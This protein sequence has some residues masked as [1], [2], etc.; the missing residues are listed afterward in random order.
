[1]RGLKFN[2][3]RPLRQT[4]IHNGKYLYEKP[5]MYFEKHSTVY[6]KFGMVTVLQMDWRTNFE[7]FKITV[8]ETIV[9]GFIHSAEL[10]EQ[11]LNDR[12]L[13]WMATHFIKNI[14]QRQGS[15]LVT[16]TGGGDLGKSL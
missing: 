9:N 3:P 16:L 4:T 6:T 2:E 10:N 7:P 11:R 5:G 1:M 15:P 12:C 14:L 13:K 8:F